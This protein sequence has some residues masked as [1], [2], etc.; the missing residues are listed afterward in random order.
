MKTLTVLTANLPSGYHRDLQLLKED[1]FRAF[2]TLCYCIRMA[3]LMLS[4]IEVN[5]QIHR[6]GMHINRSALA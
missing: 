1:L 5:E 3:A 6:S 2:E 4:N